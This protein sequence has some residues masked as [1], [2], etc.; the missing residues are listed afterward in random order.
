VKLTA[1]TGDKKKVVILGGL[2][3]VAAVVFWINSSSSGE[4][5]SNPAP[6]AAGG[7]LRPTTP[8][9][10]PRRVEPEAPARARTGTAGAT[11]TL[12]EFRPSLKPKRP[13][14]RPDPMAIDPTLRLDVIAKLQQVNV[15]GVHRNVFDFGAA[16]PPPPDP[17]VA[18]AKKSAVPN[19]IVNAQANLNAQQVQPPPPPPPPKIGWK[20][21]GFL[22][23]KGKTGAKQAFFLDGEDI[24]VV[25]E[26][27]VVKKRFKVVKIGINSVVVED[28][29]FHNQQTLPLEESPNG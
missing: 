8:L 27:D 3:V 23:G 14:D 22:A 7:I 19:P 24:H 4:I 21:Y 6:K 10:A 20:F 2:L 5:P 1:G 28:M 11:R 18:Q 9:V 17:K 12:Q 16:P 26:G 13:E 29:D 15:E 25:S